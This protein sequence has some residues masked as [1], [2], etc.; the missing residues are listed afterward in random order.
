MNSINSTTKLLKPI[1]VANLLGVKEQTLSAWRCNGRNQ[2]LRWYKFG[3]QIRYA[4]ADVYGF[5]HSSL[6]IHPQH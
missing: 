5:I 1:E 6:V 3:R 2:E 4:E